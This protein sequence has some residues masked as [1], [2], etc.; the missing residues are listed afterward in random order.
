MTEIQVIHERAIS[1]F[2]SK[3]TLIVH[4]IENCSIMLWHSR[5]KSI[6]FLNGQCNFFIPI[7]LQA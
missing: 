2:A 5:Q 3:V 4:E 1:M 7:L 6:G